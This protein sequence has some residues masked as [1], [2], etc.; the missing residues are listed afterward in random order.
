M[1]GSVDTTMDANVDTME[2]SILGILVPTSWWLHPEGLQP[3]HLLD[4]AQY[5]FTNNFS[6]LPN[7]PGIVIQ[8]LL[9]TQH[10]FENRNEFIFTN[11]CFKTGKNED[12][13]NDV[14][15]GRVLLSIL[16][17]ACYLV[18]RNIKLNQ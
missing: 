14:I 12:I 1:E 7:L 15:N 2:G 16:T 17:C 3:S 11:F 18:F 9:Y 13:V 10:Y 4:A 6:F 8:C 5:L